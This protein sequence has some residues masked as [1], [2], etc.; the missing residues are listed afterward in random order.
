MKKFL[1]LLAAICCCGCSSVE[2]KAT[3]TTDTTKIKYYLD[4]VAACIYSVEIE[5]HL[6]IIYSGTYKGGIIHA[7]HCP[8]K[9]K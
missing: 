8:C 9:I 6:Y 2:T 7:E 1:I 3:S 4:N 5:D